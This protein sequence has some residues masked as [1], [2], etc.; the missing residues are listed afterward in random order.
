MPG[1]PPIEVRTL[2]LDLPPWR[3]AEL[4]DLLPARERQRAERY[5][6]PGPRR[7]HVAAWGQ[8]MEVLGCA[9]GVAPDRMVITRE[10]GGK[11]RIAWPETDLAFNLSHSGGLAVLALTTDGGGVDIGVDVEQVRR[12]AGWEG[13]AA[14]HLCRAE[15]RELE[16]LPASRRHVGFLQI[17]T[18][19]EAW[20]KAQGTG[21][22]EGLDRFDTTS[23]AD[24]A[25]AADH[26][27]RDIS[28][29]SDHVGAVASLAVPRGSWRWLASNPR[30]RRG[31]AA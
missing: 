5:G 1:H 22:V 18:R 9:L 25:D 6:T 26:L 14:R 27:L 11:P 31:V 15:R 3:I 19:K 8:V 4:W 2:G 28:L 20:L 29:G 23:V 21:I 16:R 24:A 7:R 30:A 13:V 17:W 12:L 10:H